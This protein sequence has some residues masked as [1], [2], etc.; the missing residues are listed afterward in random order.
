[1]INDF[2]TDLE[3][4]LKQARR[5]SFRVFQVKTA[6][7]Y[8]HLSKQLFC[9]LTF[10]FG[11]RAWGPDFWVGAMVYITYILFRLFRLKKRGLLGGV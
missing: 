3:E 6:F 9:F 1:L 2:F 5:I 11:L 8:I 4:I 7:T 10:C